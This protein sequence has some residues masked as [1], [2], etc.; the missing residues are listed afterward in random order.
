MVRP[1]WRALNEHHTHTKKKKKMAQFR[2][3]CPSQSRS[4]SFISSCPFLPPILYCLY[5]ISLLSFY[6]TMLTAARV[7]EPDNTYTQLVHLLRERAATSHILIPDAVIEAVLQYLFA[8]S[9]RQRSDEY[10][11]RLLDLRGLPVTLTTIKCS[12]S[13]AA[14]PKMLWI[15]LSSPIYR[16]FTSEASASIDAA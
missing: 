2:D 14:G 5:P 7:A 1:C 12:N 4:F 11:G 6:D 13:L 10:Y 15:L 9:E 3:S 8:H 16:N